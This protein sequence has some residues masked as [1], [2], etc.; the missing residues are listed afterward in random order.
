MGPVPPRMAF[1]LHLLAGP[2]HRSAGSAAA[3]IRDWR[4]LGTHGTQNLGS[5]G[6]QSLAD[7][8][9]LAADRVLDETYLPL[10]RHVDRRGCGKIWRR[11]GPLL[12]ESHR[13]LGP[14]NPL[15]CW[16][17]TVLPVP[18]ALVQERRS[19]RDN[20]RK[21]RN[22]A[23][24]QRLSHAILLARSHVCKYCMD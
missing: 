7:V 12:P 2:D 21:D 20:P 17:G 5:G 11:E 19:R 23:E 13:F 4:Q 9:V 16:M 15:L 3:A 8:C 6:W 10:G 22:C 14:W 18:D 1:R 24:R